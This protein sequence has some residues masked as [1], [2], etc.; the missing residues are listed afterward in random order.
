MFSA[1]EFIE[2]QSLQEKIKS[3]SLALVVNWEEVKRK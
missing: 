2:G 3:A 1:M